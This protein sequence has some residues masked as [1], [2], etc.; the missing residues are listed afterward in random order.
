MK[1]FLIAGEPSGDLHGANLMRG[2]VAADPAAQFRF[3][4][5]DKMAQVG[6]AE[7]LG[8]HYRDSS[9]FGF[10]QVV[11][12]LPTILGQ[13]RRCK[14]QIEEFAPDVVILIDYAGFNLK[15]ANFA[16]HKLGI[17]T[18]FYIAPKV[19]AWNEKRIERIR[20]D[21]DELFV[22]FP[23]EGE[24]FAERGVESHFEGNPL[25]DAI[26][27]RCAKAPSRE[28]FLQRHG[29]DERPI[30]ALVAG[31]RR[32][33]IETNLPMMRRVAEHLPEYQFV[34]AGVDWLPRELY[35]RAL[36]GSDIR[37][38]ESATYEL[39]QLSEA[40]IVTSGTATLETALIGVPQV[41][42]FKIPLWQE[43]LRPYFLKIPY[44]SL[45]NINLRR[46]AVREIVTSSNDESCVVEALQ[47][48]VEGGEDR[49]RVLSDYDELREIIGESGASG[50]FARR[51]V[52]LLSEKL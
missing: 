30:V 47:R 18:Y 29:L 32:G 37:L 6:G 21:V 43:L 51:M 33:E 8:L 7:N 17:K 36:S 42:M 40:A 11:L 2:I 9:F 35:E 16:K 3:W 24:Y 41:V 22:I 52:T 14:S 31:S 46:E 48:I 20:R 44:I 15:I 27:E 45:V 1:Y 25:V 5:G 13:L 49:E 50:R 39:L 26:A 19:W 10:V 28:E 4:G 12:N 38:V 34:V 23:F